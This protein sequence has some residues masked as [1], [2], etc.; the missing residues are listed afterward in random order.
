MLNFSGSLVE[1]DSRI[2]FA[3]D[4]D[5]F[6]GWSIEVVGQDEQ[7]VNKVQRFCER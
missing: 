4:L 6:R 5:D 7:R 2:A 3:A 1:R